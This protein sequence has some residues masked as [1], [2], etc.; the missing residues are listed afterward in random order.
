MK[1]IFTFILAG[2]F[3]LILGPIYSQDH[4]ELILEER[5]V[6]GPSYA[7]GV[8]E[9][10][11]AYGDGA[12][13]K[14]FEL[15]EIGD[16]SFSSQIE[17]HS[18]IRDIV[19]EGDFL[20]LAADEIGVMM[21]DISDRTSPILYRTYPSDEYGFQLIVIGQ[22]VYLS[23]DSGSLKVIDMENPSG[24]MQVVEFDILHKAWE[25][26][27][28]GDRLLATVYGN[29]FVFDVSNPAL[30]VELVNIE[31]KSFSDGDIV[32]QKLYLTDHDTLHIYDISDIGHPELVGK[33]DS[34]SSRLV[35]IE[36]VG[37]YLYAIGTSG[38]YTIYE[39]APDN[40]IHYVGQSI[41]GGYYLDLEVVDDFSYVISVREGLVI[42]NHED[43]FN[44][45]LVFRGGNGSFVYGLD[46]KGDVCYIANEYDGLQIYDIDGDNNF[47]KTGGLDFESG[48]E[49]AY[50]VEVEGNYA[51]VARRSSGL[52]IID[53]S[54][55]Y[56]PVEVATLEIDGRTNDVEIRGTLLY[57]A[58]RSVGLVVV[59]VSDPHNP[60]ELST[61]AIDGEMY[62]LDV[63]GSY[64]YVADGSQGLYIIDV[65][66]PVNPVLS[67][68]YN[69]DM[70]PDIV[71]KRAR[72]V[73]VVDNTAYLA[74]YGNGFHIIDITD[75]EN[76]IQISNEINYGT[77]TAIRFK[78]DI[79]YLGRYLEGISIFGVSNPLD[80]KEFDT[81]NT[82]GRLED[83]A[84]S[85][86]HILTS[87]WDCGFSLFNLLKTTSTADISN[88]KSLKINVYPNPASTNF[89]LDIVLQK[90][91][92]V[93]VSI[94]D[95]NGQNL[96]SIYEG[97]LAE[98]IQKID[99]QATTIKNLNSGIYMLK[100]TYGNNQIFEPLILH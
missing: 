7:V 9:N 14:I 15:P 35:K 97:N 24:P 1:S 21:F 17:I 23:D 69:D 50:Q 13:I 51:Y 44:P 86:N 98:G 11:I 60:L 84:L 66:D 29:A 32:G 10:T 93:T 8:S 63:H 64:A 68:V 16:P 30:P 85:G 65:S 74:D 27:L 26:V 56:N 71:V 28:R 22:Y 100:V 47:V 36:I 40:I 72:D 87:E 83:I 61:Y 25:L 95:V 91:Y 90:P 79:I 39:I 2:L 20:Y 48:S 34:G 77:S 82:G 41:D 4:Y 88:E 43:K 92:F 58:Q 75:K 18:T 52:S 96:G 38:K 31:S 76:P 3:F 81:Y 80:I 55:R 99:F 59:D 19:I 89:A 6:D 94:L 53:V 70:I 78:D 67:S 57:L 46:V 5:M 42:M 54:D 33:F 73:E 45:E 12:I 37:D 62:N 49:A